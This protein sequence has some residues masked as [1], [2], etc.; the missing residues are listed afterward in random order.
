MHPL[1]KAI[2][3]TECSNSSFE[4]GILLA[5]LGSAFITTVVDNF[6]LWKAH[7]DFDYTWSFSFDVI[8]PFISIH[9]WSYVP[10]TLDEVQT[11]RNTTKIIMCESRL[12]QK[13]N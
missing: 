1:S 10:F 13:M 11:L 12:L 3:Q 7:T 9:F 6:T 5:G 8:L 2:H 4:V